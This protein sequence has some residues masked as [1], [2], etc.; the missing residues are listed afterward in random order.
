MGEIVGGQIS[1]GYLDSHRASTII[2]C[3]KWIACI[4]GTATAAIDLKRRRP[5]TIGL[6]LPAANGVCFKPIYL[7]SSDAVDITVADHL[8][9]TE[10]FLNSLLRQH[11]SFPFRIDKLQRKLI[12]VYEDYCE[13][14]L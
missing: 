8:H 6:L 7:S 13:S 10:I 3:Y 9:V 14:T 5:E 11:F 4:A 2:E 1:W 12:S